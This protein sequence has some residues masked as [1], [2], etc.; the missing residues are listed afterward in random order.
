MLQVFGAV[1][2]RQTG[3]AL[4]WI[5]VDPSVVSESANGQHP[6]F[7]HFHPAPV[8]VGPP[9]TLTTPNNGNKAASLLFENGHRNNGSTGAWGTFGLH[10][11]EDDG[12]DRS[13]TLV[14]TLPACPSQRHSSQ[15]YWDSSESWS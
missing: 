5:L 3:A 6:G 10:Q 12:V 2:V 4:R 9:F 7:A 11:Y 15:R 14:E 1:D 8:I 13:F